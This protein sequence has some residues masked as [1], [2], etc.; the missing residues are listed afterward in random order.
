M[1]TL[2]EIHDILTHIDFPATKADLIHQATAR[3]APPPVIARLRELPEFY[4]GSV[5]TVMDTLRGE[6]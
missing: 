1:V 5:N 6:E 2:H 4:Y 3:E